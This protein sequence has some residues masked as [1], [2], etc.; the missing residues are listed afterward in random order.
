MGDNKRF[1]VMHDFILRNYPRAKSILCVAD[2]AGDLAR[3]LQNSGKNAQVI[4]PVYNGMYFTRTWKHKCDLIVGLHSDEATAEIVMVGERL[5]IPY[6]IVPCC[7]KGIEADRMKKCFRARGRDGF[8]QWCTHL[9][10]LS[11]NTLRETILPMQGANL[12]LYK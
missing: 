4:D 9:Q 5:Q 6:C 2:G 1:Q 11:R 8:K 12:I 10:K 7:V 3:L